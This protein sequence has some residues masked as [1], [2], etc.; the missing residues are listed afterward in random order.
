MLDVLT[1]KYHKISCRGQRKAAVG[2]RQVRFIAIVQKFS[3]ALEYEI[4]SMLR[5]R[6]KSDKI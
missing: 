4:S 1:H 6:S 5:N 3:H 2:D